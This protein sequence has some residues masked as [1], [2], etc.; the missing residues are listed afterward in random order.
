LSDL[1]LL[2]KK[3]LDVSGGGGGAKVGEL[4]R[5]RDIERC[6]QTEP[7]PLIQSSLRRSDRFLWK[8]GQLSRELCCPLQRSAAVCKLG[9][10]PHPFGIF[11]G[12]PV[13]REQPPLRAQQTRVERSGEHATVPGGN[14]DQ[15][16]T[17][18]EPTAP[19]GDDAVTHQRKGKT[20]TQCVGLGALS[21][22]AV[23]V[24]RLSGWSALVTPRVPL[25]DEFGFLYDAKRRARSKVQKSQTFGTGSKAVQRHL[26]Y[27]DRSTWAILP[28]PQLDL[29]PS[30]EDDLVDVM[31]MRF[32]LCTWRKV[33][34]EELRHIC[35]TRVVHAYGTG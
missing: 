18:G 23:R 26:R 5:K 24:A 31:R 21:R 35:A 4:G 17:V 11:R 28:L 27:E 33:H 20:R 10:Q 2:R 30:Y 29:S 8:R 14:G 1:R 22:D 13:T 34:F 25:G 12:D 16:V 19:L 9:D 15:D 3:V 6:G 32:N 7:E